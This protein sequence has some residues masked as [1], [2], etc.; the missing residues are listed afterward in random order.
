MLWPYLSRLVLAATLLQR[1]D[2]VG[3]FTVERVE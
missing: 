1:M 3:R 2:E